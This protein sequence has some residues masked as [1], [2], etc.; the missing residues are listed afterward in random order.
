VIVVDLVPV[1]VVLVMA[2]LV[3]IVTAAVQQTFL[4]SYTQI[5][6]CVILGYDFFH[7]FQKIMDN[8]LSKQR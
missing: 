8:F 7:I 4:S 5:C 6:S 3:V 1:V 2:V